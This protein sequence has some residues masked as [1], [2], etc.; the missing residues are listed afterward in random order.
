MTNFSPA[1]RSMLP[2]PY[3]TARILGFEGTH[4]LDGRERLDG[5]HHGHLHSNATHAFG[6][7]A[8][9]LKPV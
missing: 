3:F 6:F 8:L 4:T 5:E 1:G 9:R 7:S 2:R